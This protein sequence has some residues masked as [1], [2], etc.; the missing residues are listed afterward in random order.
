MKHLRQLFAMVMVLG[1][2]AACVPVAG[3]AAPA[4]TIK[5]VATAQAVRGGDLVIGT[6]GS[7][8]PA[9][10]DG[11]VDPYSTTWLYNSFVTDRLVFLAPSGEYQPMLATGWT[12]SPD[13]KEWTL[14][15]RQDVKFQ[16]GTPFNA[17]AAK[18]N[19]DRIMNPETHSALLASYLGVDA[20]QGT[21]ATEEFTLK[22]IYDRPVPTVLWGLSVGPMWSPAAVQEYGNDFHQHL[23]GTGAFK[24]VEWT[25]GSH[26]KFV[27]NPDYESGPPWQDH[28]GAAYLDSITIKFVGDDTILGE[29]L[30]TGEVDMTSE[31]PTQSLKDYKNDPGFQVLAGNQPGTGMQMTM[32]VT[33]PPLDDLR[34]RQALRYAYDQDTLNQ[35]LYDGNYVPVYGPLTKFTRC[36]WKGVEEAYKYD[37]DRARALLDEAGWMVNPSTGMRE[38]EGEPLSL[39]VVLLH[40]QEIGEWLGTQFREIGVEFKVE[41]VPGPVQLERGVNG[42]FDLIYQ[43]NRSFEPD[44]LY[45]MWYSGNQRPGGFAWSRFQND[46]LDEMLLK[47]QSSA[48]PDERCRL[49]VEVQ[50]LLTEHTPVLPTLGTP[51]Y[52]VFKENVNGFKLGAVGFWYFVNDMYIE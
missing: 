30:K 2:L 36:Y 23:V 45:Q 19:I 18:F 37:P 5:P 10:L 17:A 13:G 15:L 47:T 48:D 35:T 26:I 9:S 38:K 31:M 51:I 43:R 32:N 14:S 40:H 24:L 33:R 20:F 7:S 44:D 34:V 3:P 50:K 6:R 46:E 4:E 21:E 27:K 12:I 16:D 8:E 41:M 29:V 25:K 1:V 52:Y 22:I 49:F 11:H 28:T 39:S 42:E